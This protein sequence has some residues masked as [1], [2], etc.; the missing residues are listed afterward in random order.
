MTRPLIS[1]PLSLS[2]PDGTIPIADYSTVIPAMSGLIGWFSAGADYVTKDGSD[3]VSA[4]LDRSTNNKAFAQATAGAQPLWVDAAIN[5]R[6]ALDFDASRGDRMTWAGAFPTGDHTKV[7]VMKC[8]GAAASTQQVLGSI[9]PLDGL[10]SVVRPGGTTN[11]RQAIDNGA[12]ALNVNDDLADDTW[13]MVIASF[14]ASTGTAKLKVSNRAWQSQT[15]AAAAVANTSL[16]LGGGIAGSGTFNGPIA[17]ILLF[18]IDLNKA[19]NES[20]LTI[21][22]RYVESAY[23]LDVA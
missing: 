23:A 20:Q 11:I 10:H 12:E 3:R 4:F 8:E 21:V 17:D 9:D 22:Q 1:L 15:K 16:F 6:P 19:A 14:D 18:N 5:G 2:D 13:A 7:L